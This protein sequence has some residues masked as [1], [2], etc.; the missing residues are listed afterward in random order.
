MFV[1]ISSAGRTVGILAQLEEHGGHTYF[2]GYISLSPMLY[3]A[4]N[5]GSVRMLDR[6]H[7]GDYI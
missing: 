2:R 4:L 7:R 1:G 5:D 6:M 3:A